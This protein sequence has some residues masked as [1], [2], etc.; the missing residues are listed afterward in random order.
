MSQVDEWRENAFSAVARL[1]ENAKRLIERLQ[2]VSLPQ[3]PPAPRE[4]KEAL[5]LVPI[6]DSFRS[7]AGNVNA[8]ADE[9]SNAIQSLEI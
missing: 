1:A 9:L 6:A 3:E 4:S 2:P 7:I 8:I 5:K